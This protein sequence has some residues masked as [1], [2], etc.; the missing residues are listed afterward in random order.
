M[1]KS[2]LFKTS[3]ELSTFCNENNITKE[4]IITINYL[5]NGVFHYAIFYEE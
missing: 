3:I 2:D 1:I 5:P 4:K